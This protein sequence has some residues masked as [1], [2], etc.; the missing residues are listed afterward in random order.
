VGLLGWVGLAQNAKSGHANLFLF[1][2]MVFCLN[3]DHPIANYFPGYKHSCGIRLDR[4]QSEIQF[5]RT[6]D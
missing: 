2:F 5:G 3:M 6:D 4:E 1:Y